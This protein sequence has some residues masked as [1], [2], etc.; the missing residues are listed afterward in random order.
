M[1]FLTGIQ[2]NR[3]KDKACIAQV[4]GGKQNMDLEITTVLRII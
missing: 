2:Y 4:K 1:Q 3:R